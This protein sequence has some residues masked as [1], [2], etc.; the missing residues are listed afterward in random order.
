MEKEN[1]IV[2]VNKPF[3][4]LLNKSRLI[5]TPIELIK[6]SKLNDNELDLDD[7]PF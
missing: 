2:D 1:R 6:D 3:V 4:S 7:I 5:Y